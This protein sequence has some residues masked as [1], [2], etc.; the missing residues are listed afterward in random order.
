MKPVDPRLWSRIGSARRYVLAIAGLGVVGALAILVQALVLARML[1][2]ALLPAASADDRL[3]WAGALVPVAVRSPGVGLVW[4]ACIV[5]VRTAAT[6]LTERAAHRAGSRVVS[7][8]RE[9]VIDHAAAMGPRWVASGRGV[10]VVALAT[11]GLNGLMPYFVKYVPALIAAATITPLAL[12]L[13]LGLDVTSAAIALVTLPLVPIFM[14][15]IGR[16]T[17]TRSERSLAAMQRLRGRMLD[18]ISGLPTLRALGRSRGPAERVRELGDA[19]RIATMG[20]LRVAFLSGLVLELLT[21]LSVALIAV[22]MGFR[23]A[24]GDIGLETAL[25]V[26]ILAPEVYLPLRNVGSHFH[27][28]SDGLAAAAAAFALLDEP[29]PEPATAAAAP[30]LAGRTVVASGLGIETPD[31]SALAP[32]ELTLRAAPGEVVA[33]VGA[34]GEGKSTALMALAGLL[35]PSR[36]TVGLAR[37]DGSRGADGGSADARGTDAR[38]AKAPEVTLASAEGGVETSG[39]SAQVAWVPQRPDL[40]PSGRALSLGQRQRLALERA[41]SSG[42]AVLLLDEPTA[43]LDPPARAEVADRARAAA[44]AGAVVIIATHDDA[45]RAIADRVVTVAS[46]ATVPS[47]GGA[48]VRGASRPAPEAGP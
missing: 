1:A 7:V 43:H 23:L 30:R 28:A 39:W 20:A 24:A 35:P 10:E 34:N 13:V 46:S 48:S 45:I 11:T 44:S 37:G 31:G 47:G 12:I 19:H 14:V 5:A 2:P 3:G 16:M 15:L 40:G 9:D 26:L 6:W 27:A 8:L 41:F 4:L 36:G 38:G 25:A 21:T 18:L 33:L 32:A 29:L 42:R 22:S 17:A